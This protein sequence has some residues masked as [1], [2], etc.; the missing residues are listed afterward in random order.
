MKAHLLT[1]S[2]NYAWLYGNKAL[3]VPALIFLSILVT[4]CGGGGGG[5]GG[6]TAPVDEGNGGAGTGTIGGSALYRNI[7]TH[8]GIFVSL[9]NQD[10]PDVL[11]G[12]TQTDSG[13][14]Y[15]FDPVAQGDYTLYVIQSNLA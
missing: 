8:A 1:Q 7:D 12:Q 13:G 3:L 9:E 2:T 15:I 5:G 4:A 10:N 14:S 6:E 11:T